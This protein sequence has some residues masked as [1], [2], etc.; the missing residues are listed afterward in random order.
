[1]WYFRQLYLCPTRRRPLSH[2]ATCTTHKD[3]S[4]LWLKIMKRYTHKIFWMALLICMSQSTYVLAKP[5]PDDWM[6]WIQRDCGPTIMGSAKRIFGDRDFWIDVHVNMDWWFRTMSRSED[7]ASCYST[8]IVMWN[9]N[10]EGYERCLRRVQI[11]FEWYHRC[12]PVVAE[13]CRKSGG[14][15]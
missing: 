11:K 5:W 8:Y 4:H 9:N 2:T 7:D 13:M 10:E 15:C 12:L 14:F 6:S 1:M 3:A